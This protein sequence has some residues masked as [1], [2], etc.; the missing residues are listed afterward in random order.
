MLKPRPNDSADT[1][2][3]CREGP[4]PMGPVRYTI[5]TLVN[6][7]AQ[8][9]QMLDSFHR[10]GFTGNT[11]E[12][13]F[14]DNTGPDQTCAYRGL[15]AIL[16][17]ARGTYVVLCHQDVRL[18][19]DDIDALDQRLIDLQARDPM[20]ALAGN[21]GGVAPGIL[22][23][24]ISDPHGNDQN[25]GNLPSQVVSLDENFIIVKAAS[26]TGFSAD[27]VGFHFYGAD[28]CLH[29]GL[30]GYTAYVIDFHLRHLSGGNKSDDFVIAQTHFCAK[31]NRV[32]TSRWIQTTCV[33][34]HVGGTALEQAVG[35]VAAAPYSKAL[36]HLPKNRTGLGL[37]NS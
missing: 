19:A 2:V 6:S 25:S 36:R 8:Y 27:L 18:F 17:A 35:R 5:G 32:L 22:A 24:R 3:V 11:T 4:E 21:A 23:L 12:Y 26:R 7:R 30:A 33:L 20:W 29:A 34:V 15:N 16:N 37:G 13:L 14:I 10:G 31:W 9:D 28:I 1:I